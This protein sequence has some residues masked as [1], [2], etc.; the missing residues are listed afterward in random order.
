MK[1]KPNSDP[2]PKEEKASLTHSLL[3]TAILA[4]A[5]WLVIL[6]ACRLIM[7]Y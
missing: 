1:L 6:V 4:S 7:G 5:C 3:V 2:F